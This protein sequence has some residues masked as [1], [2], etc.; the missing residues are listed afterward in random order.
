MC[1]IKT[2]FQYS[3][4]FIR[5]VLMLLCSLLCCV[6][7]E[8]DLTQLD[9]HSH[10]GVYKGDIADW[11]TDGCARNINH[12]FFG[13][14]RFIL[15]EVSTHFNILQLTPFSHKKGVH[16]PGRC[17]QQRRSGHACQ[18][19]SVRARCQCRVSHLSGRTQLESGGQ[20]GCA[21]SA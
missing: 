13:K 6:L 7:L 11:Q 10:L 21:S 3:S 15:Q 2:F 19:C 12:H 14:A 17:R 9:V 1:Q 18:R 8:A 4:P 20:R 16:L 5:F